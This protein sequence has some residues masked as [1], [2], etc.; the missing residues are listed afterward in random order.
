MI[1][2][3]IATT[4]VVAATWTNASAQSE[5]PQ[6]PPSGLS[7]S[8]DHRQTTLLAYTENDDWPPD[9]GTDKNYTNAL[10]VTLERNYDMWRLADRMPR[11]FGWVPKHVDCSMVAPEDNPELKCASSSW[12]VIG[13]QFYTP[14]DISIAS[15]IPNDRPYAGWLYIGGSWKSSTAKTL[16]SSDVYLG[17]TGK[18]SFGRQVQ[19]RWHALVGATTP[20]G[21]N[22]QIGGRS[23]VIIGHNRRWAFDATYGAVGEKKWLELVPY[24]GATAGNIVT[25]GYAGVRLK[26]GFN[27]SRDWA[28]TGIG[29]RL[30]PMLAGSSDPDPFEIYLVVDGQGRALGYNAFIDA[31]ST[32][33]LDRK[34]L[35]ADGGYGLGIRFKRLSFS[36]RIAFVTPEY[37]QALTHDYKALRFS[38]P[39]SRRR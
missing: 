17:A 2:I 20:M 16:V 11:L 5:S 13:Q 12:H 14:D 36:Y 30:G 35:V 7:Q 23:G 32:H 9:T 24:A 33:D 25:D 21:W 26:V 34:Y 39:L 31:A 28:E 38:F 27:I 22:H 8:Q 19:T 4:I 3:T 37:K 15:L 10:R 18:A 6:A 1:K 29:P